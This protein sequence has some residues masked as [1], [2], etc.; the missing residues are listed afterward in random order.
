MFLENDYKG[1]DALMAR[2]GE[3]LIEI[4][5]KFTQTKLFYFCDFNISRVEHKEKV[6]LIAEQLN[7][8]Q[9]EWQSVNLAF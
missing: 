6:L 3:R 7:C 5:Q 9:I 8:R 2:K 1:Q 4:K